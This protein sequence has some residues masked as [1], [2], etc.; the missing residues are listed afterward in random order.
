LRPNAIAY[1]T[2]M[3]AYAKRGNVEKVKALLDEMSTDYWTNGNQAA[4]PTVSSWNILL[5]A[6]SKR[7]KKQTNNNPVITTTT[8][9][10]T[11][12]NNDDTTVTNHNK[13]D[14]VAAAAVAPAAAVVAPH[15]A[16]QVLAHMWQLYY[17]SSGSGGGG[18]GGA[19]RLL[20][21]PPN[22]ASYNC[23]ISTWAHSSQVDAPQKAIALLR[24]MQH[25]YTTYPVEC[26]SVRPSVFSYTSVMDAFAK[27]GH[28][29]EAEAILEEMYH[30]YAVQ[31]NQSAMPTVV[32]FS[33][34]LNAWSKSRSSSSSNNNSN[35][36]K[37][38]QRAEAILVRMWELYDSKKL[39]HIKPTL[40]SYNCVIDSW[41]NSSQANA[42]QQAEAVFRNLQERYHK[43]DDDLKPNSFLYG[44]V[45][46]A[47]AKKGQ[48]EKVESL[49]QEMYHE[50]VYHCIGCLV[51]ILLVSCSTSCRSH[52]G[53][54]VATL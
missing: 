28:A 16:E 50:Y 31:G 11:T 37:A 52:L 51:Q 15:Q 21:T 17:L 8:T 23:V 43:G 46:N 47:Y 41:A 12:T 2:V 20:D 3:A 14:A 44:T 35:N 39:L 32:S 54:N 24:D 48:A 9:P 1:H 29:D 7:G 33:T 19:A 45:M 4:K 26:A 25:R 30:D 6:W 40:V 53:K 27:K 18:G 22:D 34:V 5:Y 13:E 38:L 49:L 36:Q 42:A 10:T